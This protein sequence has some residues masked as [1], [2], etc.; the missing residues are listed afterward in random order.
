MLDVPIIFADPRFVVINKPSGM[1]SVPGKGEDKADCAVSRVRAMFPHASGPLV[2]HRLDMDTSGLL[3]LGLNPDSQRDL[4]K[5]FESRQT[6]KAYIALVDGIVAADQGEISL[7]LRPD[8][9]NRPYQI[10]DHIQG[11]PALTRYRVL[12]RE[13]D[14]TRIRFEPITGRSHQLRVHAAT[15]REQGGL[16]HAILGDILYGESTSAPRL[17]LHATFLSFTIPGEATR[18]EFHCP[19]EF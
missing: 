14:R 17:L 13:T 11:R 3:V 9:E 6:E 19:P 18:R 12:A 15:P 7:P 2:V 4:S 10:V 1:L 8:L 5:Q 16:G